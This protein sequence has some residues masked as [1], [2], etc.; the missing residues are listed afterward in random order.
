[1][2]QLQAIVIVDRNGRRLVSELGLPGD[3]RAAGDDRSYFQAQV[4]QDAG[5]YVSEA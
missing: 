3:A 4:D 5:T 1:M 2:P